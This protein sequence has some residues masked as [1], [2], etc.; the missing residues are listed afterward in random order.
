M[1]G[2]GTA[3]RHKRTWRGGAR[4]QGRSCGGMDLPEGGEEEQVSN[5]KEREA[6]PHA[7]AAAAGGRMAL[8][9]AVGV[10]AARHVGRGL[11]VLCSPICTTRLGGPAIAGCSSLF[12]YVW[13]LGMQVCC[14]GL[15]L[16]AL[17]ITVTL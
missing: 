15:P 3:C 16:T 4:R 7:A 13:P 17:V 8:R 1:R 14:S 11:R 5:R 10:G 2:T 6:W 9:R 12:A